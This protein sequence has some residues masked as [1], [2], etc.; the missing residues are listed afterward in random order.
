MRSTY[1]RAAHAVT[2]FTSIASVP[3]NY[4]FIC[5][6][7][8]THLNIQYTFNSMLSTCQ[9]YECTSQQRDISYYFIRILYFIIL[10]T[11]APSVLKY[12]LRLVFF[13]QIGLIIAFWL[14]FWARYISIPF[15]ILNP[16][17]K[18]TTTIYSL[19]IL[20]IFQLI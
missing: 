1:L 14:S 15:Y 17:Y 8:K 13:S 3:C 19:M 12:V 5:S 4:T 10:L 18:Q 20:F 16:I 11:F 7:K 6:F 2:S 9:I